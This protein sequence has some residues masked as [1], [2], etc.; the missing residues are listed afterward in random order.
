M[1]DAGHQNVCTRLMNSRDSCPKNPARQSK[2]GGNQYRRVRAEVAGRLIPIA[3][4]NKMH[5]F[6]FDGH[7]ISGAFFF[8]CGLDVPLKI[9]R[10]YFAKS[11][12]FDVKNVAESRFLECG[13]KKC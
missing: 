5:L 9:L 4:F 6:D 11:I 10:K 2:N 13:V 12:F 3:K 8:G 1:R 7:A